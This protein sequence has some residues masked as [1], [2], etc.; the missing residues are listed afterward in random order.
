[1]EGIPLLQDGRPEEPFPWRT[2]EAVDQQSG[3]VTD[4]IFRSANKGSIFW[5]EDSTVLR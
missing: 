3:G 1:M 5:P 4:S 2:G